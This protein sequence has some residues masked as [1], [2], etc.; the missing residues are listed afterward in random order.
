MPNIVF[1]SNFLLTFAAIPPTKI[2]F[3]ITVPNL[4]ALEPLN[5]VPHGVEVGETSVDVDCN[6]TGLA[7]RLFK[8]QDN[9]CHSSAGKITIMDM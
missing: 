3:G 5:G 6:R 4:G 7:D 2:L 8:V 1:Q 9:Y